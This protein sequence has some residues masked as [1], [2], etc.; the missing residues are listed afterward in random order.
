MSHLLDGPCA[1]DE[2][3]R[4]RNERYGWNARDAGNERGRGDQGAADKRIRRSGGATATDWPSVGESRTQT[5]SSHDSL[6]WCDRAGKKSQQAVRLP[7]RWLS[8]KAERHVAGP[9]WR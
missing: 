7:R 1:G 4:Q 5:A 6:G 9:G 3:R 8:A 2:E